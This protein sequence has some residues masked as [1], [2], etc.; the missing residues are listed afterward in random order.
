[1]IVPAQIWRQPAVDA[2][3]TG[4]DRNLIYVNDTGYG[5]AKGI[6]NVSSDTLRI[7]ALPSS[8]PIVHL[9]TSPLS[10]NATVDIDIVQNAVGSLPLRVGIWSPRGLS[11]FFLNFGPPPWNFIHAQTLIGG[12]AGITL[13]GGTAVQNETLGQYYLNQLYH[14]E[15]SVDKKVG[16]IIGLI[17]TVEGSPLGTPMLELVGGPSRIGYSDVLSEVVP[18]G[19]GKSYNFGGLVKTTPGSLAYKIAIQWLDRNSTHLGFSGDWSDARQ[20]Q[21]WTQRVLNFTSPSNAAFARLLLGAGDN[22]TAFFANLLLADSL[23]PSVNLL[24]NGDFKAGTKGWVLPSQPSPFVQLLNP[25]LASMKASITADQAPELLSSL[26]LSLTISSSSTSGTSSEILQNYALILPH[27]T[28]E[29]VQTND[30]LATELLVSL[31][32]AGLFLVVIGT[33]SWIIRRGRALRDTILHRPQSDRLWVLFTAHRRLLA[34]WAT[35]LLVFLV[36]N[37][38][39]V[40]LGS[41]PFDIMSEEVWAYIAFRY[42]PL[43]LYQLPNTVTLATVWGGAPYH[44]AVFPYQPLMAYVSLAIGQLSR[45]LGVASGFVFGSSALEILIKSFNVLFTLADAAVIYVIM[46]KFALSQRQCI[47]SSGLFLF[48]PAVLFGASIWG[49]TQVISLLPLLA[50]IWLF[51][52]RRPFWAWLSLALTCLTR[53]QMLVPA[54]LLAIIFLRKF[55]LKENV[56]AISWSIILVFILIS[57]FLL[58]IGPSLPKDVLANTLY[59]QTAGGNEPVFNIVSYDAYSIWPLITYVDAGQRGLSRIFYSSTAPLLGSLSY[60]QVGQI[61]ALGVILIA[62]GLL[63]FYRKVRSSPENYFL[64]LALGMIGFFVFATGLAATTFV[65]GLPFLIICK[66]SLRNVAYYSVIGL[67]TMTTFVPMY[68]SLGFDISNVGYLAPALYQSTLTRY[69]MA[70]Y[71]SDLFITLGTVVNLM[72]FVWLGAEVWIRLRNKEEATQVTP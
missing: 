36:L 56:A 69:F 20:L 1:M 58:S 30:P 64:V 52:E 37:A 43:D 24:S 55:R 48:N 45:F 41:H 8:Q 23:K 38:Y 17:S 65:I 15:L 27:Q 70:L 47:V 53:P 54:F 35:L 40:N 66:R 13:I 9:V 39:L 50:S 6:V 25:F 42:S 11:G 68:G 49:E 18:V 16:R 3:Y 72:I 44:E 22:S 10:F 67:W 61:L 57:P 2:V 60:Q 28:W 63:L 71:S 21:G 5:T 33:A 34:I 31:L 12:A 62:A 14:L 51:Q 32:L 19:G 59:V 46:R 26:R 7:T 29:V 4:F